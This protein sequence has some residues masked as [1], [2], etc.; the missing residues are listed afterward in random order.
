[1][2]KLA[3]KLALPW[4]SVLVD[5]VCVSGVPPGAKY[6]YSTDIGEFCGRLVTLPP[7]VTLPAVCVSVGRM[8]EAMIPCHPYDVH[9]K[10]GTG[11][12]L[13]RTKARPYCVAFVPVQSLGIG[14][15][16]VAVLVWVGIRR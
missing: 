14:A 16:N 1:V 10:N 11:S 13:V 8:V 6:V 5:D 2:E 12:A 15:V 9:T 7:T 4:E 3:L